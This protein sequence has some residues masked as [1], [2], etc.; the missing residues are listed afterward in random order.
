MSSASSPL[1]TSTII[2][3]TVGTVVT[4]LLA[5][6]VYFDHRRR[7]DPEFRKQLKKES[8]KLAKAQKELAEQAGK[9][10]REAIKKA[11]NRVNSEGLPTDSEEIERY[12]MEEVAEGEKLCQDDSQ[13]M[14]AALCFFR[15]LKVYPQPDELV[16]IYDKTVPK[17]VLDILAEMIAIDPSIPIRTPARSSSAGASYDD[18]P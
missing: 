13:K 7:T 9:E 2:A 5:Y 10:Q 14:E 12:F 11:V 1:K 16:N 6:A 17:P 18:E 4:G 15:A 8:K 3:A